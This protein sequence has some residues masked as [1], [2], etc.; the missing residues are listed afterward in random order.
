[1]MIRYR[2][3]DGFSWA[4]EFKS[5]NQ[6]QFESS[7]IDIL[8]DYH[9]QLPENKERIKELIAKYLEKISLG[10]P[11]ET[12]HNSYIGIISK[13]EKHPSSLHVQVYIKDGWYTH[14]LKHAVVLQP[15][16][17]L[18][19]WNIMQETIEHAKNVIT[20]I[21]DFCDNL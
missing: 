7:I 15:D 6:Y 10:I 13:Y 17:I 1:M 18:E 8:I 21:N 11:L 14:H 9:K 19:S 2:I 4:R 12:F 3:T 5:E 16:N 20:F